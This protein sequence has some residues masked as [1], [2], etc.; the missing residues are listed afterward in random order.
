MAEESKL[1]DCSLFLV[2]YMPDPVRGESINIGILVHSPQDK[3]LGCL[4]IDDFR[5][6]KQ[7]HPQADLEFLREL[8]NHWEQEIDEHE[9]DLDG[10]LG[11]I[12]T[13]FSNLIQIAEPRACVLADPAEEL[14]SL[15]ARYVGPRLAGPELQD[16]RLRIKQ[17]LKS[18]FVRAG[19]WQRLE[20][21]IPAARWTHPADPFTFDYGYKPAEFEGKPNG[22]FKF[23]HAHALTRD[24]GGKL[25]KVL[26]YSLDRV[27]LKEPA[28]LTA[29]V[30]ALARPDDKTALLSQQILEEGRISIQPL[31]GVEQFAATVARELM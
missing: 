25:A 19:A 4:F 30:E 5:R 18:A 21:H 17:Q 10:Y 13:S 22:H 11:F 20:K 2:Q 27:R 3:Y 14:Q 6:V 9:D 28:Q 8:Q 16:T 12:Q 24:S 31:A 26:V 15:F 23:I 1:K 29:V 7:F